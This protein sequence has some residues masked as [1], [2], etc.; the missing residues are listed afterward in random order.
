VNV[1]DCGGGAVVRG[2][3]EG[4]GE[5][6]SDAADPQRVGPDV[7][8]TAGNGSRSQGRRQGR[9]RQASPDNLV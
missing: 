8:T 5:Q 6:G 4:G 7:T 1:E 3:K 9:V 2:R